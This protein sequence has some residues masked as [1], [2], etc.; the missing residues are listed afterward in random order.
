MQTNTREPVRT[1]QPAPDMSMPG[2]VYCRKCGATYGTMR[3]VKDGRTKLFYVCSDCWKQA[4]RNA[5]K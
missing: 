4:L 2:H 3:C 5:R 1:I